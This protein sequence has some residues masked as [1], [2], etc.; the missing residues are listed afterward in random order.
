MEGSTFTIV[1]AT[2]KPSDAVCA[3][4]V[5]AFEQSVSL[6]VLGLPAGDYTVTAGSQSATFNLAVDN[7][8]P[9]IIEPTTTPSGGIQGRV[10]HDIC[11]I[12]GGEGEPCA[13]GPRQNRES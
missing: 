5:E 6:D 10:W 4:V 2:T 13:R 3:Q 11:A 7:V 12:A 9:E 1:I 8:A